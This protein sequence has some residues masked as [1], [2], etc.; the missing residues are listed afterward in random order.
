MDDPAAKATGWLVNPRCKR[1]GATPE[2]R[3]T[4]HLFIRL[5]LLKEEIASWVDK[6]SVEG[7]WSANCQTITQSWIKRGL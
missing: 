2:P 4:K 5:D 6:A 7:G 3:T 1:D